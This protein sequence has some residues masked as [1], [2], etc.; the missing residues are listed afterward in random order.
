[1]NADSGMDWSTMLYEFYQ[2]NDYGIR[3]PLLEEGHRLLRE[4]ELRALAAGF[5]ND[6]RET[7]DAASS[8][9]SSATEYS[10]PPVPWDS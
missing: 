9:K 7:L 3:E 10:E 8:E 2:A 5:E 6:A 1:M 4:D